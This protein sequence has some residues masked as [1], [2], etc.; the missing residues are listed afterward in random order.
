MFGN[1]NINLGRQPSFTL[2]L[3]MMYKSD[4]FCYRLIVGSLA[5]S[6]MISLTFGMTLSVMGKEI[7]PLF[8]VIG[9]NAI[10]AISGLLAPS[11]SEKE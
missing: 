8:V 1:L 10:G 4:N 3:I 5:G 11:P 6:I 7:P 9:S 2:E